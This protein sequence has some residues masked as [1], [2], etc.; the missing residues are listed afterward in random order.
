MACESGYVQNGKCEEGY[1]SKEPNHPKPC[2]TDN[3]CPLV[4]GEGII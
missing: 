1:R 4:D 2:E 3:D